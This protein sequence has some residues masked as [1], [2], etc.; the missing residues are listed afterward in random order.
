MGERKSALMAATALGAAALLVLTTG[1]MPANAAFARS[2]KPITCN[3]GF[4]DQ[5]V[6]TTSTARGNVIHRTHNSMWGTYVV[7]AGYSVTLVYSKIHA[8]WR[9]S[10]TGGSVSTDI[11]SAAALPSAG[12][13]CE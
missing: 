8:V 1:V 5:E 6:H 4:P 9:T 10:I 2:L 13:L 7:S 12:R 11:N 3:G